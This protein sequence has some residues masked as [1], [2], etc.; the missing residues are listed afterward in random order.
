MRVGAIGLGLYLAVAAAYYILEFRPNARAFFDKMRETMRED[1]SPY[2]VRIFVPALG[3]Y[4]ISQAGDALLWPWNV[5]QLVRLGR[6]D[7]KPSA[8]EPEP[9]PD[10]DDLPPCLRQTI[11]DL[12]RFPSGTHLARLPI[13][14]GGPFDLDPLSYTCDCCGAKPG[15]ECTLV[16]C[17]PSQ[18][19]NGSQ[20][21]PGVS[22]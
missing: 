2:D 17:A 20:D 3:V 18:T 9:L 19:S 16:A 22:S 6:P 10:D 4:L 13:G 21:V 1:L 14:E 15:L 5:F 7:T 12:A 8:S 11:A